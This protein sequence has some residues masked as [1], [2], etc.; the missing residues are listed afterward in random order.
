M[1]KQTVDT[2]WP[3]S[4]FTAPVGFELILF[5]M[6]SVYRISLQLSLPMALTLTWGGRCQYP[7][8][9]DGKIE[10][11][12]VNLFPWVHNGKKWWI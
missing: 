8:F 6:A 12:E 3:G 10:A 1:N 4:G 9:P 2:K 11:G 5:M 7:H